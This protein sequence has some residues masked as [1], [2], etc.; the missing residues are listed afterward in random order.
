VS[1]WTSGARKTVPLFLIARRRAAPVSREVF[2]AEARALRERAA[3]SRSIASAIASLWSVEALGASLGR[4]ILG[5]R[6]VRPSP[7]PAAVAPIAH[8]GFAVAAVE[9][10]GFD[11]ARLRDTLARLCEPEWI[12]F[13]YESVGAMLALYARD[14]FHAIARALSRARLL[15]LVALDEPDAERF[16]RSFDA[17]VVAL[18]SHG[19][20]RFAY[21]KAATASAAIA[22]T[23]ARPYLPALS[24]I[25]GVALAHTYVNSRELQA[26]LRASPETADESATAARRGQIQALVFVEWFMPGW[27]DRFRPQSHA[28]EQAIA[29]AA[30]EI[31]A[32]R[33]RGILEP[34]TSQTGSA[35]RWM[36]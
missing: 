24:W 8:M 20:G 25:Q 13:A 28:A 31:R 4:G 3:A 1:V 21:F 14:W 12:G 11:A 5:D 27:L 2:D 7:L 26:L 23:R 32:S 36:S 16:A 22:R 34:F 33:R 6:G 35:A 9:H 18:I 15:P 19:Y 30:D 29:A 17:G 10:C